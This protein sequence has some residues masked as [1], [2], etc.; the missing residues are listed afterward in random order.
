MKHEQIDVHTENGVT[1]LRLSGQFIG[2][3]ETD[4]L[5][6]VLRACAAEHG[7]IVVVDFSDVP[8]INSAV[9]GALLVAHASIARHGGVVAL[10]G[11]HGTLDHVFTITKLHLV[12][13]LFPSVPVALQSLTVS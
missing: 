11:I 6:D 4:A 3:E 8:Y 2:G 9:I 13:P 7:A 12:F 5:R 1:V 10:S